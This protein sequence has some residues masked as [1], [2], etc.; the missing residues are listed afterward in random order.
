MVKV[1][2]NILSESMLS[3]LK[4]RIEDLNFPWYYLPNSAYDDK[5]THL[6]YSFSHTVLS[7]NEILSQWFDV[8]NTS[9]LV[10]KD[11]FQLN[12]QYKITRLR[13]GMTTSLNSPHKHNPHIDQ[14]SPHKTILFYLQDSDGDTYFYNEKKEITDSITP[15]INRAVLFDGT[16][17]HSSSKPIKYGRR[18]VLNINLEEVK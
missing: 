17:L 1:I 12:S 10:I 16:L 15:K 18:L 7:N 5:S 2:D 6:N 11:A 9:A 4:Q 8:T 3:F 13:W 14:D